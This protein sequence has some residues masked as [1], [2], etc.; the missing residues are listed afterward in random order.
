MHCRG[1]NCVARCCR[2]SLCSKTEH[3]GDMALAERLYGLSA[4]LQSLACLVSERAQQT[5][6]LTW[7]SDRRTHAPGLDLQSY[8]GTACF[9]NMTQLH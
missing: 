5:T 8:R 6:V 4:L 2:I 1:I 7:S 3:G 9:G